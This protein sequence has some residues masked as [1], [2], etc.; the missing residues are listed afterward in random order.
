MRAYIHTH[1]R[2]PYTPS[3]VH[4]YTPST[5]TNYQITL[6]KHCK[7]VYTN[8]NK[9]LHTYLHHMY[10]Y[11]HSCTHNSWAHV[12]FHGDLNQLSACLHHTHPTH[13]T[14][15]HRHSHHTRPPPQ[16]S[17]RDHLSHHHHH[18]RCR[19]CTQWLTRKATQPQPTAP[20]RN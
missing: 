6:F 14:H 7:H 19:R 17:A 10:V 3:H 12:R 15:R 9:Y 11:S 8:T 2:T 13:H 5:H 20:E 16:E 18:H 4:T 1:V